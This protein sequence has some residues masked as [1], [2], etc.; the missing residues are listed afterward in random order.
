MSA[1][2]KSYMAHVS[3]VVKEAPSGCQGKLRRNAAICFMMLA[4]LSTY[5]ESCTG[6]VLNPAIVLAWAGDI[7]GIAG[8]HVCL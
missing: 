3:S 6:T 5:C 8:N 7:F 2:A 4:S 1:L